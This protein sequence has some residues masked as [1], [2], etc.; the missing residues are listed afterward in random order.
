MRSFVFS[1]KGKDS[2]G[3]TVKFLKIFSSLV[4]LSIVFFGIATADIPVD[5]KNTADPRRV[6]LGDE[7]KYVLDI[8]YPKKFSL[9]PLPEPLPVA[10]F[11]VKFKEHSSAEE[12]SRVHEHFLFTLTV[13]DLGEKK[14]PPIPIRIKDP[15]GMMYEI[16][17]DEV[18]IQ[19]VSIG[20]PTEK[21]DI[22]PIKGPVS[23]SLK[24]VQRWFLAL[25][26]FLITFVTAV[27]Y[28]S[29]RKRLSLDPESLLPPHERAM[30][31]LS[32]LRQKDLA[33]RDE[34]I[35]YSELSDILR[36]YLERRFDL[37]VF[38]WTTVELVTELKARNFDPLVIEKI[39]EVLEIADLV[40][41]AKFSPPKTQFEKLEMELVSVVDLT[42]PVAPASVKK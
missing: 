4:V 12:R 40:K 16:P 24:A 38:E 33:G 26:I 36:R 35:Y 30:R 34:K 39:R 7:I 17:T 29:R 22:R 10:P 18:S 31:E 14:I 37:S 13:F 25:A 1:V 42:K 2:R 9:V 5:V 32:R 19:V 28:F 20:K 15:Q 41:F 21:A 6:T 11:E 27:V 8:E 3:N 23:L